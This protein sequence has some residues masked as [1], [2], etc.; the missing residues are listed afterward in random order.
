MKDAN[1]KTDGSERLTGDFISVIEG[2][3][4]YNP[5]ANAIPSERH[6]AIAIFLSL[7]L[8]VTGASLVAACGIEASMTGY[9]DWFWSEAADVIADWTIG[10]CAVPFLAYPMLFV[11]RFGKRDADRARHIGGEYIHRSRQVDALLTAPL[12]ILRSLDRF[13]EQRSPGVLGFMSSLV[14]SGVTTLATLGAVSGIAKLLWDARPDGRPAG[15]LAVILVSMVA[16]L[17]LVATLSRHSLNR[18]AYRRSV[19]AEALAVKE[20]T[21]AP[22]G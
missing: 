4:A 12:P 17:A 3:R 10:L 11:T 13:Y 6:T 7:G 15:T 5:L 9:S 19:V 16:F 18:A 1:Q 21:A 22:E 20:A 2:F 8:M 14:G